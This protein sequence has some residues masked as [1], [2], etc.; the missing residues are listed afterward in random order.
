M[1]FA[2][3]TCVFEFIGYYKPGLF[4]ASDVV[5]VTPLSWVG[6]LVV[7]IEMWYNLVLWPVSACNQCDL[8]L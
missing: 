1:D 7:L 6:T 2:V 8:G 5:I 4:N 3:S